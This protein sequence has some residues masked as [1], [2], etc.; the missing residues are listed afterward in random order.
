M[1]LRWIARGTVIRGDRVHVALLAAIA[2]AVALNA[3]RPLGSTHSAWADPALQSAAAAV[4]ICC[5]TYFASR[6]AGPARVWRLLVVVATGC[7][8]AAPLARWYATLVSPGESTPRWIDTGDSAFAL[9]A[10]AA[11][12]VLAWSGRTDPAEHDRAPRTPTSITVPI[13]DALVAA[14]SFAV[15]VWTSGTGGDSVFHLIAV[16]ILVAVAV[17]LSVAYGAARRFRA[18][19]QLLAAGVLTV[20][21]SDRLV[22]YLTGVEM[23][24]ATLWV[25]GGFVLGLILIAYATAGL[26]D[27]PSGRRTEQL[28]AWSQ[29]LMPHIAACGMTLFLAFHV[30]AGQPVDTVQV[31]FSVSIVLLLITRQVVAIRENRLLMNR[32]LTAQ[33]RLIHQINH[34]VLTG[35]PNRLLF[36]ERLDA[37]VSSG[38]PFILV[39]V[40]LDD[41]KDVNDQYGHA[42]GDRLLRTVG[43]RLSGCTRATDTVA[44]IGGDEFGMLVMGELGPPE[45]FADRVRDALRPPFAVHGH[46]VQM[47]ASMGL[48]TPDSTTPRASADEFLRRADFSMYEGK[49]QGKNSAVVYRQSAT[50][51]VDFATALRV[52]DGTLPRDFR[53]VYQPIVRLPDATPV[54]LEA[55][56]RW[57]APNGAQISPET[58]VATAEAAGLGTSFDLLVLDHVCSEIASAEIDLAIHVNIG[59][60]R[61]GDRTFERCVAETLRTHGIA[62]N[63]VVLEITESLPIVDLADGAAAIERLKA[64]GVRVALDDFGAGYNTLTYLHAL[65]VDVVKLDRGLTI[66]IEPGHD[67][68]LYRSVVGIC[69]Q[70]GLDVIAEGIETAAQADTILSAGCTVAQGYRFGRPVPIAEVRS[71]RDQ[72]ITSANAAR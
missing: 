59:A 14:A 63:Q 71:Q 44:R 5:G 21:A 54:A 48:V 68:V 12:V 45:E 39:Y 53:I 29:L 72:P 38:E 22:A 46:S 43:H 50:A 15:L 56:A 47:H 16:L 18:N 69:E 28:M 66:G 58:F 55:L 4:A 65:P 34:D 37:A 41:F 25:S 36:A 20:I 10:S 62:P 33:R 31:G 67:A 6:E 51:A 26:R 32:V 30:I 64:D 3:L 8:V 1:I 11:L 9:L 49:R 40:D 2:S 19:F 13:L 27:V 17:S 7:W 52:A 35:L 61:L 57:T 60:A 42:A 23:Y 70:L 24:D